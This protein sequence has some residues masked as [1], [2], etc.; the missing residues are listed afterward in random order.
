MFEFDIT[1]P[2]ALNIIMNITCYSTFLIIRIDI[3]LD[4][5]FVSDCTFELEMKNSFLETL[6]TDLLFYKFP[7][8]PS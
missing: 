4:P 3:N 6:Y 2:E 8:P 1:L 5:Y 7:F